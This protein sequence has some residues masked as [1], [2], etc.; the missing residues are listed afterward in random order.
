M[1]TKLSAD[2]RYDYFVAK[3]VENGE[4]WSLN[5]DEGWVE[6]TSDDGEQCLPL[7]PHPELAAEW[8]TGEWADCT[9]TAIDLDTWI[10]RWTPGLESDGTL[11][12]VFPLSDEGGVVVAPDELLSSME[13]LQDF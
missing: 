2:E 5:S 1:I 9:P 10:T 7:W 3:A 6:V 11:L 4:V 13:S 12:A 8:I